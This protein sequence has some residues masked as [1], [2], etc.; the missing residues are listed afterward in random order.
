[1]HFVHRHIQKNDC[2]AAIATAAGEGA[3]A[4][5][6]VSGATVLDLGEKIFSGP[7]KNFATH[8]AH[9]GKILS[10]DQSPLDHVL[11]LVM[12]GPR[13][14]TGEDTLEISCHGGTAVTRRVLERIYE[15]G[16]RPAEPGEFS[17]RAFLNGKMDLA[18]A[19]A[20]QQLI[21]AKSEQALQNAER[22]LEGILSKLIA[23]FQKELTDTAAILEAWVDFPEE[24]LEF[25]TLEEVVA[26]M[27]RTC[28]NMERLRDTFHNG[29][30]LQEGYS[31]CLLGSPNVG[32]SSLM[33]ALLGE[34]RAIVTEIA[35]T[36]RD[37]LQEDLRL[38]KLHFRL[39]DTA[40]IRDTDEIVEKEGIRRSQ[41]AMEQA[42]LI[43]LLLDASRPFSPDDEK[44]LQ[45]A[46]KEKTIL[47]WNKVDIAQPIQEMAQESIHISA[48]ER[49]GLDTL[50]EKIEKYIWKGAL[51]SKEEIVIT[52]YRHYIALGLAIQSCRSVIQGLKDNVSAE[53]VS[54][55]MRAAL[56][57]L[58]TIL[59]THVSED[60][61]SAIFSKFCLG[62]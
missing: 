2:I 12:K 19:E 9:Y 27:E 33:N 3:I 15:A 31:L 11:L 28:E 17:L 50:I 60:I 13:S 54:S 1:M 18:Q 56:S 7:I 21:A 20:V 26:N 35:G 24:G 61:L 58:G 47:V 42:D 51:P 49:W 40:G 37:L 14:Y 48:K 59:G 8:T 36:T 34:E 23:Q 39:I 5:I 22:Q 4:V 44:L 53:F 52:H 32:K 55:D 25:A 16:A 41:K 46:P 57:E 6:R 62:K 30:G 29:R 38:G 10:A 45:T 43:L